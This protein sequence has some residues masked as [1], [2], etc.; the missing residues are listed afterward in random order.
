MIKLNKTYAFSDLHGNYILWKNIQNFLDDSDIAFCLGDC[1]DRGLNGISIMQEILEDPRIIYLQGNH[2]RMFLN[3]VAAYNDL[4]SAYF[5]L[6]DYALWIGNGGAST[7]EI[8]FNLDREKQEQ[9]YK[10]IHELKTSSLYINKN[11]QNIFLCHAGCQPSDATI[12]PSINIKYLYLWDR[13]HINLNWENK[14]EY[15]NTFI[16][17]GHTPVQYIK[18]DKDYNNILKYCDNHKISI[19]LG[20]YITNKIA[21]LDLDSLEAIYFYEKGQV[22]K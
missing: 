6:Q 12:E 14:E 2:E 4:E 13:N 16:I 8:Y 18:K 11:N 10:Q 3:G 7:A 9:L 15:K 22:I 20:S 19:D 1:C 21:L 5:G 17:H